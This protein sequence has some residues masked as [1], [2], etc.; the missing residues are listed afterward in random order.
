MSVCCKPSADSF[1]RDPVTVVCVNNCL[2]VT[3]IWQICL[4]SHAGVKCFWG[5][6]HSYIDK[7]AG[8]SARLICTLWCCCRLEL[9]NLQLSHRAQRAESELTTL[10]SFLTQLLA[11]ATPSVHDHAAASPAS[12]VVQTD[13]NQTCS[14][15]LATPQA[16]SCQPLPRVAATP[17]FTRPSDNQTT[18]MPASTQHCVDPAASVPAYRPD[19]MPCAPAAPPH[20]PSGPAAA[21]VLPGLTHAGES[22]SLLRQP[23]SAG[24]ASA[25][26]SLMSHAG[27]LLH[28]PSSLQYMTQPLPATIAPAPLLDEAQTP[29]FNIHKPR[30]PENATCSMLTVLD[31][32]ADKPDFR[33]ARS[34]D[35]VPSQSNAA[36]A[37]CADEAADCSGRPA[38]PAA[39]SCQLQ[40]L[41]SG[42]LVAPSNTPHPKGSSNNSM[43]SFGHPMGSIDHMMG[44]LSASL[45]SSRLAAGSCCQALHSSYVPVSTPRQL[46]SNAGH[47][48]GR[49]RELPTISPQ[50]APAAMPSTSPSDDREL[51]AMCNEQ[52]IGDNTSGGKLLG[53]AAVKQQ[54]R[55]ATYRQD[56][57]SSQ[58]ISA[59]HPMQDL[60]NAGH[61]LSSKAVAYA[62]RPCSIPPPEHSAQATNASDP[63][64][65]TIFLKL[66]AVCSEP[67]VSSADAAVTRAGA[68]EAGDQQRAGCGASTCA[69]AAGK[70]A[71]A[72]KQQSPGAAPTSQC[73][74]LPPKLPLTD[75]MSHSCQT[76]TGIRAADSS[77]KQSASHTDTHTGTDHMG[78]LAGLASAITSRHQ[79][80]EPAHVYRSSNSEP[81]EPGLFTPGPCIMKQISSANSLEA[82]GAATDALMH[83]PAAVVTKEQTPAQSSESHL[84]MTQLAQH[85]AAPG[86]LATKA[87]HTDAQTCMT[88]G[89]AES[90]RQV[91]SFSLAAANSLSRDSD[92]SQNDLSH[93]AVDLFC[94]VS[95]KDSQ[96]VASPAVLIP[97]DTAKVHGR[98]SLQEAPVLMTHHCSA[99]TKPQPAESS[100]EQL[101]AQHAADHLAADHL[102]ADH[103]AA[104]CCRPLPCSVAEHRLEGNL[105]DVASAAEP[106][107]PHIAARLSQAAL[108]PDPAEQK[109]RLISQEASDSGITG[110]CCIWCT[111]MLQYPVLLYVHLLSN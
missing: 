3:Y 4:I 48:M 21:A 36:G 94:M 73:I 82:Q 97:V 42:R 61:S 71:G 12:A 59:Q 25:G 77:H 22:A 55:H 19:A 109:G 57:T 40:A 32:S 52:N 87:A 23:S 16:A 104:A 14:T 76:Q 44:E 74:S 51:K 107:V 10:R 45:G 85:A 98:Q 5:A 2:S 20:A 56:M 111:H 33:S 90:A 84:V 101:P 105:L 18:S 95:D 67:A 15:P 100:L 108:A 54:M 89:Q 79:L 29:P 13:M 6:R 58:P 43:S 96:D 60:S 91:R 72:D 35:G 9:H 68:S 34:S 11:A 66:S 78:G 38:G 63:Q 86:I 53:S 30:M 110:L 26:S 92:S 102:A 24:Q 88:S 69:D 75:L 8:G 64:S 81:C 106:K 103:L 83:T 70:A 47:S 39:L 80:A 93:T 27:S 99:D 7:L 62:A 17:A 50:Q 37:K 31:M 65:A 41:P 28:G 46:T 1:L 49:H